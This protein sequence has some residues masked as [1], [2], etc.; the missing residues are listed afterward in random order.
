MVLKLKILF[1][2]K[3]T[4]MDSTLFLPVPFKFKCNWSVAISDNISYYTDRTNSFVLYFKRILTFKLR[5]HGEIL[6][7]RW[8]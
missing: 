5:Q 6:V 8:K 4:E 7:N 1:P 2:V 3:L